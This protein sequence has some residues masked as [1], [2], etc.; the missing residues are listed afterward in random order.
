MKRMKLEQLMDLC[1][2]MN[3]NF[4][5]PMHYCNPHDRIEYSL[6]SA[7]ISLTDHS[8]LHERIIMVI[9]NSDRQKIK[10]PYIQS[11]S[12]LENYIEIRMEDGDVYLGSIVA[13]PSIYSRIPQEMLTGLAR[14]HRIT[15]AHELQRH[16]DSLLIMDKKK[17]LNAAALL[18]YLVYQIRMDMTDIMLNN[19][20]EPKFLSLGDHVDVQVSDQRIDIAFHHDPMYE[21]ELMQL[22]TDGRPEEL[23]NRLELSQ[24]TEGIGTLSRK[25]HVRHQ[26]NLSIVGIALMT[27]AAVEGGLH[28]EIAYTMS[29][30]YIQQIEEMTD[31]NEVNT[32]LLRATYD[33]A[34]RVKESKD[35]DYSK[36]VVACKQYIFNHLYEDVSLQQLSR[37][38]HMNSSYLSRL[39]KQ[40]TGVSISEYIQRQRIEEAK[41]LL[42]LTDLSLSE[43][44]AR[45]NF[46][47]QSYFTKVFKKL[48][49]V[50]PKQFRE[51]KRQHQAQ[52]GKGNEE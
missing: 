16:Y 18:Y 19:R 42:I 2:L 36:A 43:I 20:I 31:V 9:T 40:E 14:D 27:R 28:P 30:L 51:G 12:L 50:T 29:D 46:T 41:K 33:F 23:V 44:Y 1:K 17:L 10:G 47:D 5:L 49:G 24:T 21:K 38:V 11:T 48:A 13:G 39:F 15:D 37:W 8:E 4:G 7:G 26:K 35:G 25:S 34:N 6:T 45:L 22:V 32:A 3:D 52:A